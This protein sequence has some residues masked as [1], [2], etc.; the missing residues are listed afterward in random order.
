MDTQTKPPFDPGNRR[1][2][3]P[4][5]PADSAT[6][7]QS[8]R[9][10]DPAPVTEEGIASLL[11]ALSSSPGPLGPKYRYPS[12]GSTYCVRTWLHAK[13]GRCGALRGLYLY[14]AATHALEAV[15][16]DVP[17]SDE[18]HHPVNQPMAQSAA[19][20]LYLAIELDEI[21]PLYDGFARDFAMIETGAMSELLMDH[22]AG[23]GLG[24][25]LVGGMETAALQAAIG[26][27]PQRVLSVAIM[28]GGSTE[29]TPTPEARLHV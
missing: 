29:E 1:L 10:F 18:A 21:T 6:K 20:A 17:W 25:C 7:R 24:L 19:F 4:A 16:E 14:N 9:V 11:E 23:T 8:T 3:L 5:A 26:L 12:A 28:G 13:D 2:A 15:A 27:G 22:V